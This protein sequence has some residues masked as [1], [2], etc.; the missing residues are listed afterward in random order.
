[1]L[2]SDR[3]LEA[4]EPD[5]M[6]FHS[7]ARGLSRFIRNRKTVP[8]LTIAI[9]GAWGTGKSSLMN[10]LRTDLRERGFRPVWFNAWHYQKEENLLA[11]LLQNVRL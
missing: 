2:V 9:S 10:L 3:P 8:P 11:S 7:I 6:D 1:M 5:P 4:G